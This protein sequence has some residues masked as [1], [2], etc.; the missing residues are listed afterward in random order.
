MW[1]RG[2]HRRAP[3]SERVSLTDRSARFVSHTEAQTSRTSHAHSTRAH[4]HTHRS[5]S[6]TNN[7]NQ[8]PF[9]LQWSTFDRQSKTQVPHGLAQSAA[10]WSTTAHRH[11]VTVLRARAAVQVLKWKV[12][13][14]VRGARAF[15]FFCPLRPHTHAR[16]FLLIV[17]NRSS[18]PKK[19]I[20]R[21]QLVWHIKA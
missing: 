12:D 11:D 20:Y 9:D 1:T 3:L 17:N 21:L 5:P 18:E 8:I 19:N 16:A 15:F 13:A 14:A 10:R 2:F 6:L 4:T 7:I